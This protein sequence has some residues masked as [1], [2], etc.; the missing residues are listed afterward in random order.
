M[1]QPSSAIFYTKSDIW[2]T[3]NK[4]RSLSG[5]LKVASPYISDKVQFEWKTGDFLL[6]ALSE[7]NVK[8]GFVNPYAVE[9]LI[10]KGVKVYSN[11]KLHA[12]IYSNNEQ[13]IICSCNL[14]YT[15]QNEWLEAGVL[16]NDTLNLQKVATF[17]N[18]NL[19][20][21]NRISKERLVQLKPLFRTESDELKEQTTAINIEENV[22]S[23]SLV[24]ADKLSADLQSKIKS[25]I[26]ETEKNKNIYNYSHFR[27]EKNEFHIDDYIIRFKTIGGTMKIFFPARCIK[28]APISDNLFIVHLRHKGNYQPLEWENVK[29]IFQDLDLNPSQRKIEQG[30]K[31]LERLYHYFNL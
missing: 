19:K 23:I 26:N 3:I 15:S 1:E 28:V 6:I 31:V 5:T 25:S 17:F 14:S 24:D 2:T 16:V 22:W 9:E 21:A 8:K 7:A 20:D 11:D 27:T 30:V 18:D 4:I 13:A 12:K 10:E 29:S